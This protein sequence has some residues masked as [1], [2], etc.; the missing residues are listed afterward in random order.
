MKE[1]T[2]DEMLEELGYKISDAGDHIFIGIR[3]RNET[4]DTVFAI[5]R[6]S[7]KI[8]FDKRLV[9]FKE[10]QAINKKVEES[11]WIK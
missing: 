1:K 7:K 8:T 10:L 6:K 11:G 5:H 2:A 3:Y 9:T 4:W